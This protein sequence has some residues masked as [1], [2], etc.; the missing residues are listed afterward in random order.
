M[1]DY[2]DLV[3][4]LIPLALFGV[5]GGLTLAGF[6]HTNALVVGGIVSATLIG[7]AMFVNGPV[8]FGT[9]DGRARTTSNHPSNT[10]E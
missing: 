10:A 1:I 8:R 2:Y 3:L 6:A 9:P 7:H 5:G 4:G